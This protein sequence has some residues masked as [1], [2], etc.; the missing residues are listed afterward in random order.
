MLVVGRISDTCGV[1][2]VHVQGWISGFVLLVEQHDDVSG[3]G[4]HEQ[5][6]LTGSCVPGLQ[7]A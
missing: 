5:G 1:S 4:V 6:G 2:V 7:H 3:T